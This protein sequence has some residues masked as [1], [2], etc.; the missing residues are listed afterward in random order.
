MVYANNMGWLEVIAGGM[1][2]GKSEELIRRARRVE[3]AKQSLLVFNHSSDTRYAKD[4]VVSHNKNMLKAISVS[5]AEDILLKI[6][7]IEDMGGIEIEVVCIDE[8]QFFGE[9]IVDV[10]ERLANGG[11]RVIVA[12]LDMDFRGEPFLVM[13]DLMARAEQVTKLNA[14]C[15]CGNPASRTQRLVQGEPAKYDDPIILVG[16]SQEYRPVCRKCHK[17][18]KK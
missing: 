13:S 18:P 12:G 15:S 1:F 7:E 16:A 3:Y 5:L 17:V 9:N 10:C 2:S 14:I 6:A 8:V 4:N 11:K